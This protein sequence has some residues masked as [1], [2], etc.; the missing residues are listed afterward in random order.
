MRFYDISAKKFV[1]IKNYKLATA[2]NGR[3]YAMAV[4]PLSGKRVTVFVK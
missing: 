3:K 1:E 2:K 4:S